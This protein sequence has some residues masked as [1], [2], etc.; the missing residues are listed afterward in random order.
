MASNVNT[1][2]KWPVKCARASKK[3]A[4][5]G[6]LSALLNVIFFI[7]LAIVMDH[8]PGLRHPNAFE[9]IFGITFSILFGG[10]VL[11][12]LSSFVTGIISL[13][14]VVFRVSKL[15]ETRKFAVAG[16]CRSLVYFILLFILLAPVL[17]K[18][19]KSKVNQT[20]N[21]AVSTAIQTDS[22]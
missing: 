3:L 15:I 7:L 22:M 9:Q 12:F 11:C 14:G 6:W 8:F 21:P 18:R 1:S 5:I 19:H 13:F 2:T 17:M 4:N 10:T 16:I 20:N